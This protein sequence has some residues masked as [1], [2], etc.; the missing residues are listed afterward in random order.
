MAGGKRRKRKH[1]D[2]AYAD[3]DR[4][5]RFRAKTERREKKKKRKG[6]VKRRQWGETG[7][8]SQAS[9]RGEEDPWAGSGALV[10]V[11][12]LPMIAGRVFAD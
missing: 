8:G 11:A 10:Q 7:N 1:Q 9:G 4:E 6:K 5:V 12:Y 3:T 2:N